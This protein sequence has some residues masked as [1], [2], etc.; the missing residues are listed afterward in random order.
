MKIGVKTWSSESFLKSFEKKADFFE[1][2]AIE[3]NK[4]EFLKKFSKPLVIHAQHYGFGIN[5]ADK[6]IYKK[7]LKSIN[8]ARKMAD[9]F[10]SKIIIMHPGEL[11]N[12]NCSKEQA[13]KF[14][15]NIKD[16]RILIENVPRS[17]IERLCTT[18]Q[19]TKEFLKL[20]NKKFCLDINHAIS[21]ALLLKQDYI[22]VLK[23][24]IKLKP[25]HYHLGGQK[26][27][28]R[29]SGKL[30]DMTHLGFKNSNIPLKRIMKIIPKNAYITLEVTTNIKKTEY[31]LNFIKNII[32]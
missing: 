14:A 27:K 28:K 30:K 10:K 5:H 16:K 22:K 12:K 26:I 11:T 7:N 9:S 25:S 23:E 32:S 17:K 1:I 31:D 6:T 8:F 21:T 29:L 19:E 24:F 20:T 4:Y 2:Q 13:I 15:K 18:P 3:K